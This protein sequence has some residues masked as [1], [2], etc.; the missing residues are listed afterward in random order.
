MSHHVTAK[1]GAPVPKDAFVALG[2]QSAGR[3]A[4]LP[5]TCYREA[6]GQF[7]QSVVAAWICK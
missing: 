5:A 2:K 7:S 6:A 4:L 1:H 3:N